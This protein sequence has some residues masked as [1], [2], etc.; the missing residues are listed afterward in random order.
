MFEYAK[1]IWF[2]TCGSDDATIAWIFYENLRCK[3]QTNG[4]TAESLILY[5]DDFSIGATSHYL[6]QQK[7]ECMLLTCSQLGLEINHLKTQLPSQF[8]EI[9]GFCW[10]HW[11]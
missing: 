3:F 9:L 6:C 2:W 7:L 5:I 4:A 11:M 10:E 8:P 1:A